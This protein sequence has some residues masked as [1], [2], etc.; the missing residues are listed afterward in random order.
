M[1]SYAIDHGFGLRDESSVA[2]YL[3]ACPSYL[4]LYHRTYNDAQREGMA[5]SCSSRCENL[6]LVRPEKVS[7][8]KQYLRNH[9]LIHGRPR[10]RLLDVVES[11]STRKRDKGT[12]YVNLLVA[13]F[14]SST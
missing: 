6:M 3:L 11:N 13:P 7:K 10:K 4:S 12:I 5:D 9:Y 1:N 14:S 2:L 8:C